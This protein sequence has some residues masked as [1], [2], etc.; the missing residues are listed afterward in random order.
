MQHPHIVAIYEIGEHAGQPYFSME[1][2]SGPNLSTVTR[3][4]PLPPGKA[5]EYVKTAA[6]AIFRRAPN[7]RAS[8]RD[9]ELPITGPI[10]L[11]KSRPI[12]RLLNTCGRSLR[13]DPE[14]TPSK[15]HQPAIPFRQIRCDLADNGTVLGTKLRLRSFARAGGRHHGHSDTLFALRSTFGPHAKLHQPHRIEV[16]VLR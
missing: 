4:Q 11:P 16:H 6:E 15:L 12:A 14:C 9:D 13:S 10:P 2:V 3:D 5:A 1:Y 7:T 8:A